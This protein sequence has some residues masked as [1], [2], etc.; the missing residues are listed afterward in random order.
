MGLLTIKCGVCD[1]TIFHGGG[2]AGQ[3]GSKSVKCYQCGRTMC[4]KCNKGP[5]CIECFTGAP[6][7]I[8]ESCMKAKKFVGKIVLI[9][10]LLIIVPM[11]VI[12][13]ALII[14]YDL[15]ENE[16]L[17]AIFGTLGM[18][19]FVGLCPAVIFNKVYFR[20]WHNKHGQALSSNR[21]TSF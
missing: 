15:G 7:D 4:Q 17:L 16:V 9:D 12:F 6:A 13:L 11:G 2:L 8:Q 18:I 3:A 19:G 14:G 20:I 5:L 21:V 10:I 1:G